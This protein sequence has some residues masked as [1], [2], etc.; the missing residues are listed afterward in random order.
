MNSVL[1]CFLSALLLTCALRA[2]DLDSV[3]QKIRLGTAVN[4][5]PA[6]VNPVLSYDM[7]TLYF[8]RKFYPEN[9]GSIRDPDDIWECRRAPNGRWQDAVRLDPPLNTSES[10][11]LCSICPLSNTA[12]LQ[13]TVVNDGI[14]KQVFALS[15]HTSQGW[16]EPEV[17]H[18]ENYRND[19]PYFYAYLAY[20]ERTLFLALQ[21]KHSQGSLDLYVSF[22]DG[23]SL[24]FSEPR[25]LGPSINTVRTEGSPC[26]G[27]DGRT[28]YFSSDGHKGYGSLDLFVSRRLDS[29]WTNWSTPQNLGPQI[30]TPYL[31]HC[32]SLS[33]DGT[34]AMIVSADSLGTPGIYQVHV[35]AAMQMGPSQVEPG[36][37]PGKKTIADSLSFDLHFGVDS[38]VVN[39]TELRDALSGLAVALEDRCWKVT[40]D[41]WTDNSGT[42]AHNASLSARRAAAVRSALY[43]SMAN[44]CL[45]FT[46]VHNHGSQDA[47]FNNEDEQGRAAN[48]SVRIRM[49][50]R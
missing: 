29:T 22:R 35:P 2:G 39:I 19:S 49:T 21:N 1:H 11:V 3:S 34:I 43:K 24:N 48:R 23:I 27:F 16:S 38:A 9:T 47:R 14:A 15:H 40:L 6:V 7:Q 36:K 41:S 28:L 30:N 42:E 45:S 31:D 13:T 8:S 32:F 18:I 44:Q 46:A 20:D 10:N 37:H 12:L 50:L 26:L 5:Y 33:A 4:S 25:N 17:I